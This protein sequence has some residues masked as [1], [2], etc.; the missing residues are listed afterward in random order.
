MADLL[1]MPGKKEH[2]RSFSANDLQ[3]G[4]ENLK[5]RIRDQF[6]K[7]QMLNEEELQYF[8]TLVQDFVQA[9]ISINDFADLGV[10]LKY[11]V[12]RTKE[13]ENLYVFF[14]DLAEHIGEFRYDEELSN[15]EKEVLWS[16]VKFEPD[17]YRPLM[18]V[19][20]KIETEMELL[21][22]FLLDVTED[23][24]QDEAVEFTIQEE[25]RLQRIK[26]RIRIM[27]PMRDV[28]SMA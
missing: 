27:Q 24:D 11:D 10:F 14:Q 23:R 17:L 4:G 19:F 12:E 26:D 15:L 22:T 2:I 1:K 7:G 8:M 18:N 16:L 6:R 3:E 20:S 21:S 9:R 28:F 25:M 13:D 5:T